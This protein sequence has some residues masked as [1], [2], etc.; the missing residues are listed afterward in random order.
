MVTASDLRQDI[1]AA[2]L[3]VAGIGRDTPPD[4]VLDLFERLDRIAAGYKRLAESGV[5]LRAESTRIE[6]VY[7]ILN[8]KRRMAARSLAKLGGLAKLR[9]RRE[10]TRDNWWWYIDEQ[11]EQDRANQVRRTLWWSGAALALLV[12]LIAA[13]LAFLRP[14]EATRLHYSYTTDGE[15]QVEAGDYQAALESYKAAAEALPSDPETHL[16]IGLLYEALEQ[17]QEADAAYG[18]A[19]ELYESRTAFLAMRS[20][21]YS[22]VGWFE[23]GEEDAMKAVELDAEFA[24]AYFAL[25]NSYE[26]RGQIPQAIAALQKCADLASS[27]GQDELYVIA[28]TRLA[29]LIQGPPV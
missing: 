2:E 19:E 15:L 24:L 6:T 3:S 7:N 1:R 17:P 5:D 27:Q 29:T 12:V 20:I 13:Y 16:M 9:A 21:R 11:L 23:Q 10:P 22:A 26:G 8:E 25:A 18:K 14:D 28:T 4:V